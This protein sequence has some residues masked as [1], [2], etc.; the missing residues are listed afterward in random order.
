MKV[1]EILDKTSIGDE[2]YV[3]RPIIIRWN[4]MRFE[5]TSITYARY[6][7][8][9][10]S[11]PSLWGSNASNMLKVSYLPMGT[12]QYP[13]QLC[14]DNLE[15]QCF[16]TK[17]EAEVWKVLELQRLESHVEKYIAE[18]LEKTK[19]KIKKIKVEESFDEYMEKY[20]EMILK[21][22]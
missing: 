17:E 21:V 14:R 9:E 8:V 3:I 15:F 22:L 1:S 12:K 2:V 20:P 19:K 6:H 5:N 13:V 10:E 11:N 16:K 18:M 4:S 7:V